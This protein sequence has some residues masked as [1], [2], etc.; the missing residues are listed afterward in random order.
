MTLA[1]VGLLACF[2]WALS[3]LECD[4]GEEEGTVKAFATTGGYLAVHLGELD[5]GEAGPWYFTVDSKTLVDQL[6]HVGRTDKVRLHYSRYW[7]NLP[8]WRGHEN[9]VTRVEVLK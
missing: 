1:V 6:E 5:R 8:P 4:G 2:G 9:V 7:L 3:S